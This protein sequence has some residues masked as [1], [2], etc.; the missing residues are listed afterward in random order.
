MPGK[1]HAERQ[2][3]YREAHPEYRERER[4]RNAN[5]RKRPRDLER[6]REESRIRSRKYRAKKKEQLQKC[7]QE[8]YK[9]NSASKKAINR[10][11]FI[12]IVEYLFTIEDII[13]KYFRAMKGLNSVLPHSP[14]K[15]LHVKSAIG[16]ALC[17]TPFDF[18]SP[19]RTVRNSAR[20]SIEVETKVRSFYETDEISRMTPG[21]RDSIVVRSSDGSKCHVQKV[22]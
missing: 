16:Q 6:E 3:A 8:A 5:D 15:R 12:C 9:T 18:V 14:R 20:V 22:K 13:L 17:T 4:I 19:E 21:M 11:V 10:Y 1:T 7:A 2:K